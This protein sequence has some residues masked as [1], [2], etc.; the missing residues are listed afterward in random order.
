MLQSWEVAAPQ[1]PLHA[2]PGP[3]KLKGALQTCR[4]G[5]EVNR[6][7]SI[8]VTDKPPASMEVREMHISWAF[9]WNH[10]YDAMEAYP[11]SHEKAGYMWFL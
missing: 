3:R 1:N 9:R 6:E 5:K 10:K 4:M 2:H 7:W 11:D 8:Q